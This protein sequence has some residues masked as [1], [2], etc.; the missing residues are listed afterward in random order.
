MPQPRINLPHFRPV[1][2]G[3]A[4][5][6]AKLCIQWSQ[7]RA[8]CSLYS[9]RDVLCCVFDSCGI[10]GKTSP[11]VIGKGAEIVHPAPD[12]GWLDLGPTAEATAKCFLHLSFPPSLSLEYI[13]PSFSL[14]YF[15]VSSL[16]PKLVVRSLLTTSFEFSHLSLL[17]LGFCLCFSQ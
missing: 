3:L 12:D 8:A 6:N 11:L 5:T 4:V 7:T 1:T 9:A 10:A 17:V 2:A 16:T 14:L 13:F 15:F